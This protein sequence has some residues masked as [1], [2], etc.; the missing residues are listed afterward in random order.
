MQA[1]SKLT[2]RGAML[3]NGSCAVLLL[4]VV[5]ISCGGEPEQAPVAKRTAAV[6]TPVPCNLGTLPGT[7]PGKPTTG[8]CL[9]QAP[10]P[11]SA[12][13]IAQQHAYLAEWKKQEAGWT[14]LTDAQREDQRRQLKESFMSKVGGA[15]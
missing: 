2:W 10:P 4:L 1:S 9:Q 3:K 13:V 8:L 15:P 12:A 7:D 14:G 11:I 5:G 6:T